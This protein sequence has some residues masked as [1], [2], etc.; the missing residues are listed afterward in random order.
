MALNGPETSRNNKNKRGVGGGGLKMI[1]N[2]FIQYYHFV[3]VLAI[4][5]RYDE[6]VELTMFLSSFKCLKDEISS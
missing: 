3:Q 2:R 5:D 6:T 1:F 4:K